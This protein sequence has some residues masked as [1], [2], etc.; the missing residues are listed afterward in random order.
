MGVTMKFY[1]VALLPKMLLAARAP[2][3][4]LGAGA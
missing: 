4:E 2:E 3:I 1:L